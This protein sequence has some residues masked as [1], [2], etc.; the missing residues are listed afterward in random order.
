MQ[1]QSRHSSRHSRHFSFAR[2]VILVVGTLAVLSIPRTVVAQHSEGSALIAPSVDLQ[3]PPP[4][5]PPT[6]PPAQEANGQ[7]DN[8]LQADLRAWLKPYTQQRLLITA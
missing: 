7:S 8:G 2:V 6:P 3:A 1:R 4:P 5:P